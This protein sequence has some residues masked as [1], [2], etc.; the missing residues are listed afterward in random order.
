M[1]FLGFVFT[2]ILVKINYVSLFRFLRLKVSTRNFREAILVG[3]GEVGMSGIEDF[4][5]ILLG[6]VGYTR[7]IKRLRSWGVG[8]GVTEGYP[9][10]CA[11]HLLCAS[12]ENI[13]C[14]R[15]LRT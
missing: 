4:Y 13:D 5:K 10:P 7:W 2:M 1:R 14:C 9:K 8:W 15:G 3:S 6:S 11:G 12:T